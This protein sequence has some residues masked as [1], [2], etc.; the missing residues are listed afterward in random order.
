MPVPTHRDDC[1]T[2][3]W[4]TIC[5]DCRRTVWYFSCTCGSKIFFD[6][7]GPPWPYHMD[8]CPIYHIR[9]M[10]AEGTPIRQIRRLVESYSKSQKQPI[11]PDIQDFLDEKDPQKK[12]QIIEIV[13]PVDEPSDFEGF[14]REI[15]QINFFRRFNIPDNMIYRGILGHLCQ[16][17]YSEVIVRE[18]PPITSRTIRQ[19]TLVIP[20][21]EMDVGLRPG[22]RI[23]GK[24]ES[25]FIDI[26]EGYP[27]WIAQ[28]QSVDWT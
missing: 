19:W 8:S 27:L 4:R 13:D 20:S 12:K 22:M 25:V 6:H 16:K 11:P 26:D 5:P 18:K 24:L 3:I 10:I 2:I 23:W 17:P 7:K 9:V 15:K 14:V 28:S 21:K 1:K